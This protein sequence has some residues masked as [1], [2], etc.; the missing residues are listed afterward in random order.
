MSRSAIEAHKARLADTER[1]AGRVPNSQ[2][3]ESTA[4][5]DFARAERGVKPGK[6]H[7]LAQTRGGERK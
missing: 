2:T 6:D 7:P 5:A 4:R 3:I 1:K